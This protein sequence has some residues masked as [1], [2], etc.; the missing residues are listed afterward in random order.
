MGCHSEPIDELH[1]FSRWLKHV[2]TTN[3][4]ISQLTIYRAYRPYA[5][6]AERH[7]ERVEQ[8]QELG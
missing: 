6:Q 8:L 3:Q 4:Y 2:K 7:L 5:I 1:H